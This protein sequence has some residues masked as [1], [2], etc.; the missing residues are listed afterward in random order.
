[1][2]AS[3][4]WQ[5][6]AEVSGTMSDTSAPDYQWVESFRAGNEE[7][8][9][10]IFLK[11]QDYVYNICLGILGNPDDACDSA[12][13]TFLRVHRNLGK[14]HQRASLSTWIYRIAVNEC[15]GRLR[16]R[17]PQPPIPLEDPRA[18]QLADDA[19]DLDDGLVR[20]D[21]D[22]VVRRIVSGMRPDYRAA[23]VLRYFQD[24]SYEE[25]REVL[26]WT[27]P[28]VKVKLHRARKAFARDYAQQVGG[29]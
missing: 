6:G 10:R 4:S 13:E 29:R 25:M 8:F 15:L 11:Y 3:L 18:T 14:F 7:A 28:Q 27:L 20:A 26:G 5:R 9:D 22:R 1:M 23:L 24:L 21:D 12:Q 19:P 2:R 16:R 17:R